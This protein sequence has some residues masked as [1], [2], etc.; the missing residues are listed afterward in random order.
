MRGFDVNRTPALR[1]G[2]RLQWEPAQQAHVLLYPEGMVKLNESAAAIVNEINGR[3]NV[4]SIIQQLEILYPDA[5]PT[6][7]EDVIQFME[8]AYEKFW[9]QLT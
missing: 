1:A 4:A 7:A 5:P 3:S 2:Y 8:A 6:L 9:L